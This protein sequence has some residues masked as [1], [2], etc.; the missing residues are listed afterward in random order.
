MTVNYWTLALKNNSVSFRAALSRTFYNAMTPE[1]DELPVE[2]FYSLKR[3]DASS[4]KERQ[5]S[6]ACSGSK[7]A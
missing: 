5:I 2:F 3:A 4:S 1:N 7:S 6:A